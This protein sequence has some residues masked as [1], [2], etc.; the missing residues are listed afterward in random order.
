MK[1][2]TFVKGL[3]F[4]LTAVSAGTAAV[5]LLSSAE[6]LKASQLKAISDYNQLNIPPLLENPYSTRYKVPP[7]YVQDTFHEFYPGKPASAVGISTLYSQCSYLGPTI[8]VKRGD[9]VDFEMYNFRQEEVTNHWHGLHIPGYIDGGPHQVINVGEK[10]C[11]TMHINQEASTNWYHSHTCEKTAEQVYMGHAGMFIIE[12]EHS[13]ALGLP[14][15]YGVNDIPV[16]FQDKIIDDTGQQIY[17]TRGKPVFLGDKYLVNGTLNPYSIV[18]PGWVRLRILNASNGRDFEIFFLD[19]R[20]FW[21]IA[22]DGGFLNQPVK[23]DSLLIPP[24]ERFEIMVNFTGEPGIISNFYAKT[25]IDLQYEEEFELLCLVTSTVPGPLATLPEQLRHEFIDWETAAANAPSVTR[26]FNLSASADMSEHYINDKLFD[27]RVINHAI[28][29]DTYEVWEITSTSGPHPFHVHGC[30]FLILSIND[31]PPGM[32]YRGWKDVVHHTPP[33]IPPGT[34]PEAGQVFSAKILIKFSYPTY[35]NP[36]NPVK[37]KEA[38]KVLANHMPYM[39][40]CHFLE[41]EDKGMMGQ[42]TVYHDK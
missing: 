1:R 24:G 39:Y 7:M 9:I 36:N 14:D 21:V 2:R 29:I 26:K 10:L 18:P 33:D 34:Q 16:I 15:L 32:E 23:K 41:H 27:M 4:G 35:R 3:S 13:K 12:D 25:I 37:G 17:D 42:F 20:P 11:T 31:K 8:K 5:N 30:S 19:E 38:A 6:S 22:S 28:P 40:H